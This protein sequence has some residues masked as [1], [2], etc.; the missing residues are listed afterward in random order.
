[1]FSQVVRAQILLA[2][3]FCHLL[4]WVLFQAAASESQLLAKFSIDFY[5][6]LVASF[7]LSFASH[8]VSKNWIIWILIIFRIVIL[9]LIG[10]PFGDDMG[11]KVILVLALVVESTFL[12]KPPQD[13]VLPIIVTTLFLI[14]Q[15][16]YQ[17]LGFTKPGPTLLIKIVIAVCAILVILFTATL[18]RLLT[19]MA[20]IADA[21]ASLTDSNIRLAQTNLKFQDAF[22]REKFELVREERKRIA[23][24]VHDSVAYVL[25]NLIMMIENATDLHKNGDSRLLQHLQT[26]RSHAQKGL[27]DIRQG[28][29]HLRERA[30][31]GRSD[32]AEI[33]A[34]TSAFEKASHITVDTNIVSHEVMN[35]RLPEN[36]S[37]VLFRLIQESVTNAVRHGRASRILIFLECQGGE[38]RVNISDNGTGSKVITEGFGIL[39]MKERLAEV[40]G[41]IDF[42]DSAQGFALTAWLPIAPQNPDETDKRT[43]G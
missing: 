41:R 24:E 21:N 37:N 39:G 30:V 25:T 16:G 10:I 23:R 15:R 9:I 17:I 33:I 18:K 11:V 5:I 43:A 29:K 31:K 19:K 7:S 27:I 35:L 42:M 2:S 36:V 8:V 3:I 14:A 6:L 13:Y 32:I 26:T 34:L 22:R 12:P 1:M 20:L 28:I 40:N 4:S 38:L